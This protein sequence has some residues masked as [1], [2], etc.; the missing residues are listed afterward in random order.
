MLCMHNK[1]VKIMLAS[2][3]A[4]IL[5]NLNFILGNFLQEFSIQ[6]IQFWL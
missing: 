1:L 4:L 2:R 3:N 6:F 5:I